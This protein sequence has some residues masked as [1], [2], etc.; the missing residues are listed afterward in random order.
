MFA[1]DFGKRNDPA[2]G[3][4]D[5]DGHCTMNCSPRMETV[6]MKDVTPKER[7]RVLAGRAGGPRAEFAPPAVPAP[8]NLPVPAGPEP[9]NMLGVIAR[10]AADPRTDVAKMQAL[11]DMQKT[12]M[13]DESKRAFNAAFIALQAEMPS[14]G[15]DGK[16]EIFAKDAS[17]NR[18]T[19]GRAQQSTPYAT[20]NNIMKTIKPLLIKHGFAL[21]FSTEPI[22][23]RL[24]V[25]GLLEGHGHERTTAFPLAAETSG[26]KN[27]AQG[28][29]S[30]MSY[31]KRYCTIALLNIVSEAPEDIDTDGHHGNFKPAK[32][33]AMAEAPP[34][35]E[36]ID[37]EQHFKIRELIE[38]CGVP[39]ATFL[40]HYGIK[41]LSDLPVN[42]FG[43][44]EKSCKDF[45][46]NREAKSKH[47]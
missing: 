16:I 30:S 1:Y 44:A 14:I 29:G 26:S 19:T 36:T 12:I 33:G 4:C 39:M 37:N 31:G 15:R 22:G 38:W 34:E 28:W 23:E 9:T 20:F 21:S 11:L 32:G 18:P 17:G 45:H 35:I 6:A 43:A 24:N 27:N 7:V 40:D 47:G 10:A 2:C 41:K 3:D 5:T 13:A 25:K 42:L 8:T 46:A